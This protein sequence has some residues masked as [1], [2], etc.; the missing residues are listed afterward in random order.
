VTVTPDG[1]AHLRHELRTPLNHIIGYA[2]LLL[3]DTG[4]DRAA[5][6]T[7]LQ[8]LL[9]DARAVLGIV[10]ERLAPGGKDAETVDVAALGRAVIDPVTRIVAGTQ[11]L[12]RGAE[13]LDSRE[14][15]PDLARI[16][17]AADRLTKLLTPGEPGASA[18]AAAPR[19]AINAESTPRGVVLVVDDDQANR[20]LLAR[21]LIREGFSVHTAPDGQAGLE[22]LRRD[23]PP[24]I[25]LVLLDVMMPG[26]DGPTTF[27]RLQDD[28]QTRGIPVILLTAKAQT[29]DRHRFEELG[30]AGILNKP[31]DP[32]ALSE[33]VAAILGG[34]T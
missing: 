31:F 14:L 19:T 34:A 17:E 7:D 21:R 1:R 28:P 33:Q 3:E 23:S 6:T 9:D 12:A 5:L 10:N 4:A 8:R 15:I 24:P 16:A 27:K 26:I 20:D 25:D 13:A 11:A 30:V 2:E 32:M 29:A 22:I 18:E